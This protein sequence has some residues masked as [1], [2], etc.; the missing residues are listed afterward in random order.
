MLYMI[1]V[2][3][4]FNYK[5]P[6]RERTPEKTGSVERQAPRVQS[7]PPRGL[8]VERRLPRVPSP[9]DGQPLSGRECPSDSSPRAVKRQGVPRG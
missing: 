2:I 1:G 3:I 8:D 7:A 6:F 4:G 9:I 5:L